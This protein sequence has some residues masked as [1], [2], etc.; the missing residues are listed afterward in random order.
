MVPFERLCGKEEI[1]TRG[2]E[3]RD[4]L[5]EGCDSAPVRLCYRRFAHKPGSI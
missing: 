4:T 5:R 2:S 1:G 3:L